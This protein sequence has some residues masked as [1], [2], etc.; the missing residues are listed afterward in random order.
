MRRAILR[1]GLHSRVLLVALSTAFL[2]S[3]CASNASVTA[4]IG[5]SPPFLPVTLTVDT[6][7]RIAIHGNASIVTP[8]VTFSIGA[9]VSTTM[10]SVPGGTLLI[11]RHWEDGKLS[12][13]VYTVHHQKIV[14]VT[15]GKTI[16]AVTNGRVF[17]DVSK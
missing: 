12:D 9:N 10:E 2:C 11:I 1:Q 4:D 14:V 5:Y 16:I 6:N 8:V 13:T 7:G 3:S 17:I 15:N